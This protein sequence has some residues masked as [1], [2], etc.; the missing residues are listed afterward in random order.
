MKKE[1]K[2]TILKKIKNC[3]EMIQR[4]SGDHTNNETLEL[5]KKELKRLNKKIQ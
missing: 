4:N 2:E 3:K 1:T 5:F